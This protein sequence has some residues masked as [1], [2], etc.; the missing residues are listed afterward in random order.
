MRHIAIGLVLAL[1]LLIPRAA[2][3]QAF[4]T[5]QDCTIHLDWTTMTHVNRVECHTYQVTNAPGQPTGYWQR[6]S[7]RSPHVRERV[8]YPSFDLL[9]GCP[10]PIAR[11]STII[12]P[13]SGATGV[14]VRVL[15]GIMAIESGG[16]PQTNPASG[17]AGLMQFL[18]STAASLGINPWNPAQAI[19]A[20]GRYVRTY[21]IWNYSG[22]GYGPNEVYARSCD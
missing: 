5:W 20:A 9:P 17:A 18:P 11:W 21:G 4:P 7:Y 19:Y 1:L 3:A 15:T 6:T 8:R 14:P 22:G 12:V 13:A 16:I 10:P 2:H